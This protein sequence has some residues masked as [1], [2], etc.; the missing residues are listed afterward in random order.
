MS[1]RLPLYLVKGYQLDQNK[2][3]HVKPTNTIFMKGKDMSSVVNSIEK[4]NENQLIVKNV[5]NSFYRVNL[6]NYNPK[7]ESITSKD[8]GPI[9]LKNSLD[10]QNKNIK[11]ISSIKTKEIVVNSTNLLKKIEEM[12][13]RINYL[14]ALN[15]N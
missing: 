6:D 5:N 9:K 11:G 10:L 2:N 13:A 3:L 12:E 7:L 15:K 14:E 4:D 1:N 8:G